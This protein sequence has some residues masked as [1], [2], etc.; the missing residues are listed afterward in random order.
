MEHLSI[1]GGASGVGGNQPII[2]AL[3]AARDRG[4]ELPVTGFSSWGLGGEPGER[5]AG[6][7]E[8]GGAS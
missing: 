2:R 6:P 5:V 1:A 8:S 3:E 7:E 4:I